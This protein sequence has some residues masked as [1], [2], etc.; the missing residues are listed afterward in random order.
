MGD[1]VGVDDR[2]QPVEQDAEVDD[3]DGV[4]DDRVDE[5]AEQRDAVDAQDRPGAECEQQDRP[6]AKASAR[7]GAPA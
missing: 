7:I 5:E 6:A 4:E 2:D 1:P 3:E